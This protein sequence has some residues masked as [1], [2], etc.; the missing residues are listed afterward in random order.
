MMLAISLAKAVHLG[1]IIVWCAGLAAL[2]VMLAQHEPG[3]SQDRYG[4]LRQL[5]HHGY[6]RIVAPAAVVAIAAGTALV[7]L[8][9]VYV[10]WMFA[11]LLLVGLLVGLHAAVG[12]VVVRTG[13]QRG[14]VAIRPARVLGT[15]AVLVTAILVLVLVK[16]VLDPAL[17][18][19]WAESP[20]DRQL[21]LDEVPT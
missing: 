10:P 1:A 11:K 12:G 6:T 18:P 17:L 7:F 19:D 14:A 13:E 4:R 20:L 3:D 21:P 9:G 16:P 5:S 2:P 15:A 8:R